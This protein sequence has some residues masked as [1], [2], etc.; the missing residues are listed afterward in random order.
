MKL[1]EEEEEKEKIAP[2]DEPP[3]LEPPEASRSSVIEESEARTGVPPV[4]R[5]VILGIIALIIIFLL[6]LFAR[7]IYHSVHK[8]KP[9]VT[10][11]T[12]TPTTSLNNKI[13]SESPKNG[14]SSGSG[15][16]QG[17]AASGSSG[18]KLPNNGPG[19][20]VGLFAGSAIAAAGLHYIIS[21]RRFNKKGC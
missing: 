21:L 10:G 4:I 11:N 17:S 1:I 19:N 20:V 7:W 8:N 9:A 6:V 16:R 2:P 5:W 13:G 15:N 3:A 14:S 12:N 18:Q